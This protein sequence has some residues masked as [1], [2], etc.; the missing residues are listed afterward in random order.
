M[1]FLRPWSP[2]RELE[3]VKRSLDDMMERLRGRG[4]PGEWA[5]DTLKPRIESF[6]EDGWL[7]IRTE[8]AG[9]D[10][11]NVSIKVI[12]DELTIRAERREEHEEKKRDFLHR[13]FRYGGIDRSVTLPK[14]VN[15]ED[16]NAS[17]RNGLLQIRVPMPKELA[18][19][20]IKIQVE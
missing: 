11:K 1:A 14:G 6:V 20:E 9:V 19:K 5:T 15:A 13:E 10:P 12:G 8:L 4:E 2:F 3:S 16:M 7:I 18:P 17:F